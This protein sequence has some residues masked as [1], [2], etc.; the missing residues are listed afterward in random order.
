MLLVLPNIYIQ[1]SSAAKFFAGRE[2]W[3]C[4]R[5]TPCGDQIKLTRPVGWARIITPCRVGR[6]IGG[7]DK[8]PFLLF[9]A[10]HTQPRPSAVAYCVLRVSCPSYFNPPYYF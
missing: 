2:E 9:I 4:A 10:F 1:I 5:G 3:S 7:N 6:V 8:Y